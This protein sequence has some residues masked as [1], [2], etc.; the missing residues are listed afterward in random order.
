M[1]CDACGENQATLHIATIIGG[2]K[3]DENLCAQCWQKRNAQIMGGLSVGDLLSQLL[4]AQPQKEKD[5]DSGIHCD[6]CGMTYDEFRASGRLGCA[7]CYTA[8]GDKM[9]QTLKGIHGHTHHVGKV[10]EEFEQE[11][12]HQRKLDDLKRQMDEAVGE[13]DFERAAVL[14]DHIKELC[15]V[16]A[17]GEALDD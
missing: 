3:K 8:F 5:Q 12:L 2:K 11:L 10:P 1:L 9:K 15:A 13:E 6:K 17:E 7:N 14:R 16:Q 4:G